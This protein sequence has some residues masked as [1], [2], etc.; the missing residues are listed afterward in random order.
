M[1][2]KKH[3]IIGASSASLGALEKIRAL[4]PEDEIKLITMEEHQPYS[5][6]ALPYII[7]G[8][9]NE[10]RLRLRDNSYFESMKA[11]IEL[12]KEVV[13]V[14]PEKKEVIYKDGSSETYDTLL[15]AT[16]SE[17]TKID[18]EG[19]KG[20]GFIGFH[21]LSDCHKLLKEMEN[22]N[23][24]V[25][26]GGGLVATE[27]A[28]SLL[29][30]GCKVKIV[31]RSRLLRK[32]FDEEAGEI[33]E[34]I[35]KSAGA[36]IYSGSEIK[37]ISKKGNGIEINLS[38][39]EIL[40]AD[41][42][43]NALGVQPRVSL[44]KESGISID[45]GVIVDRKM[46]TNIDDVYAAGDIAQALDFFTGQL[47]MNPILPSAIK[48]GKIAGSNMAGHEAEYEG[49]IPMNIFQLFGHTA[50]SVGKSVF[51]D[52]NATVLKNK[53]N[54]T[55]SF[56]K[57]VFEQGKL[58]GALFIDGDADPGVLLYL[59]KKKV[60]V[61]PHEE[62]LLEETKDTARWLMLSTEK[63]ESTLSEV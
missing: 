41:L 63:L 14:L 26:Y 57:L 4:A 39:G 53:D 52:D 27:L 35:L 46:R 37:Q 17:P 36:E 42:F 22:K 62:L 45:Q 11:T 6:A 25:I 7:S 20:V 29:E 28:A 10:E 38:G 54:A 12:G 9:I 3:L 8:R 61:T 48:Q 1:A 30:K 19:L 32:Y 13:Q 55:K 15:I 58:V 23:S 31:V 5:P 59:I 16:G 49:D 43:V 24:I 33:I 47:D 21:I 2:E 51:T 50:F 34:D 56:R 44:L 40:D 60:K 18:I